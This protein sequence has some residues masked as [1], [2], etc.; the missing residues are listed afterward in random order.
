VASLS[1]ELVTLRSS[2]AVLT[3]ENLVLTARLISAQE[4]AARRNLFSLR[5]GAYWKADDAP[6]SLALGPYCTRCFDMGGQMVLLSEE[7]T[8]LR[9]FGKWRCPACG[10]PPALRPGRHDADGAT[11]APPDQ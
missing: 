10:S 9:A 7:S 2:V 8:N 4:A 6:G 11:A 3:D 1:D 5:G